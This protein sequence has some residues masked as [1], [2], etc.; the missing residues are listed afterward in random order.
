MKKLFPI[1]AA[2]V[3]TTQL[4]AKK[5][6]F[7]VDM[8]GQTLSPNGIHVVGDFQE[9][10]GLG[11]NWNPGSALLSK[12]GT[13][14]IYSI[15]VN[16]PAFRKYEYRFVNGDQTYEA[17]FV[18][19]ESR[20]GYNLVDNRWIYVDSLAND[21]TYQGAIL[22]GGNAPSGKTLIRYK[23]N[24]NRMGTVPAAG[25]H[26]S[27][28]YYAFDPAKTRLY[29]FGNGIYEIIHFV[30]LGSYTYKF[31]NGNTTAS[32]ETVPSGCSNGGYRSIAL[33]KDT[34]LGIL[35]FGECTECQDVGLNE[36]VS[37]QPAPVIY[38]NPAE[39]SIRLL[40]A[41]VNSKVEIL[42]LSGRT[43]LSITLA[44]ADNEIPLTELPRG[45]YYVQVK[46]SVKSG[47]AKLVLH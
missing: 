9:V 34:V 4:S 7:A 20:V 23:L 36:L 2:L 32:G 3:I 21:T 12:E 11:S 40:N 5:V 27:T 22:F 8:T 28:S 16:L 37:S 24:T 35:C 26:V 17:E 41:E 6:K 15:I 43:V 31:H 33:T 47:A 30:A 44:S 42:D 10:A 19:E 14:N 45:F 13:S 29:S 39:E 1:V 46:G 25:F 38:P 18:P